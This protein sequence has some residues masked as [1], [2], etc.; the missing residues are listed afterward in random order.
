[1]LNI[2][3]LKFE[4]TTTYLN[5]QLSIQENNKQL[6]MD[7]IA[8]IGL[9]LNTSSDDKKENFEELLNSSN[10]FLQIILNNITTINQL[11][12]EI[13]NIT[14]ELTNVFSENNKTSK[15]KEYYIA[16]LANIK[17]NIATYIKKFQNLEKKLNID[18][19]N[20]NQFIDINNFK[21]TFETIENDDK[22]SDSNVYEFTGFSVNNQEISSKNSIFENDSIVLEEVVPEEPENIEISNENTENDA[23]IENNENE[24]IDE[25]TS[26]FKELLK[27]ISTGNAEIK[28]VFEFVE[29][30]LKAEFSDDDLSEAESLEKSSLKESLE[31]K[32]TKVE[33]SEIETENSLFENVEDFSSQD[34][35]SDEE[36]NITSSLENCISNEYDLFDAKDLKNKLE[37]SSSDDMQTIYDDLTNI[38]E[39]NELET[40]TLTQNSNISN[41]TSVVKQE[42]TTE[43]TVK[44]MRTDSIDFFDDVD[45]KS[46]NSFN[47]SYQKTT[48]NYILEDDDEVY[49][50]YA[51]EANDVSAKL[52]IEESDDK[53]IK[54]N[55]SFEINDDG[56]LTNND[57]ENIIDDDYNIKYEEEYNEVYDDEHDKELAKEKQISIK[58]VDENLSIPEKIEKIKA[59]TYDNE[60]LII[61]ENTNKVYLPY[62]ISELLKY[63]ESYPDVYTSLS[64]VVEQEFILPFDYFT[65][66]PYKVRFFETFNLIRNRA[67]YSVF[68]ALR[69]SLKLL[70]K[71]NLNPAIIAACKTQTE[72]KSLLYHLDNDDLKEFKYFNI[73]FDVNPLKQ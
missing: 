34:N 15:T 23:T 7:I 10:E 69:F 61:S 49:E 67:G 43:P 60:T 39:S 19:N 37:N 4:K 50:N 6:I 62:K 31:E 35:V 5:N 33:N 17:P 42:N 36:S 44:P 52:D 27:G 11:N 28:D 3:L 54:E 73:V 65:K 8:N 64:D 58:S 45:F 66:H 63:V 48:E 2:P 26:E 55:F 24:K 71:T 21:Y 1:M 13:S 9:I 72:L 32:N 51:N 14:N 53:N 38:D 70:Y 16:S 25:L 29:T 46:I 47:S 56:F 68:T 20:F 57:D 59:A 40:E 22:E 41:N 30:S 12:L 18:N